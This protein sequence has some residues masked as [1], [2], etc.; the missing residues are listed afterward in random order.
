[1]TRLTNRRPRVLVINHYA[2]PPG[3]PG[4]TRHLELFGRM[5]KFDSMIIASRRNAIT[6]ERQD[7]HPSF[8]FVWT[9]HLGTGPFGRLAS[10]FSFVVAATSRLLFTRGPVALVYA[11]SPHLLAPLTGVII[12]KIRRV[13]LVVEIRDIWPKVLVEMGAFP[14]RSPIVRALSRLEQFYYRQADL[15]VAM[16]PQ[17]IDHMRA[18]GVP[19]HRIVYVPNGADPDDFYVDT[20]RDVLRREFQFEGL[21]LLYAGAHGPANGLNLLLDAADEVRDSRD[22]T[23]VLVG[24]GPEKRGLI[25]EAR[26]RGLTNVRFHDP[27]AKSEIPRLLAAADVGVHVLADVELFQR[28]VSPNKVFDYMAAGLPVLTNNQGLVGD[29]VGDA[30][31]GWV[32]APTQLADGMRQILATPKDELPS[33]GAKGMTWVEA[34]QSRKRMMS[35]LES[36]FSDVIK[37]SLN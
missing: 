16:A 2:L 11:S 8:R 5:E 24:D 30:G 21:T 15:L 36:R 3:S 17:T 7:D 37:A 12:A 26:R 20:P 28:G 31:C 10:W 35:R 14:E 32:V 6:G 1:M 34:N 25:E 9:A 4:G 27:V 19:S 23:I 18:H 22:I 29:I 13:P 33:L